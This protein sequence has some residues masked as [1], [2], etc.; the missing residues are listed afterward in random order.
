MY[1]GC[2]TNTSHTVRGSGA[3]SEINLMCVSG[4]G[5]V[6]G[7][8]ESIRSCRTGR[9]AGEERNNAIHRVRK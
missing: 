4:P 2:N 3:R 5:V 9:G 1:R 7:Q 8:S 6:P